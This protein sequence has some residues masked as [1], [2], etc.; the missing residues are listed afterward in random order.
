M[1]QETKRGWRWPSLT[2]Q[3]L[4]FSLIKFSRFNLNGWKLLTEN[5]YEICNVRLTGVVYL[6]SKTGGRGSN[7]ERKLTDWPLG[8]MVGNTNVCCPFNNQ[9]LSLK[10]TRRLTVC[11]CI[12]IDTSTGKYRVSYC[13]HA[14]EFYPY[15]L[16]PLVQRLL[17][18]LSASI[19]QRHRV[20]IE[21]GDLRI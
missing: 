9:Q 15:L 8:R 20:V 12:H 2:R 7:P 17:L 18:C 10:L 16:C 4:P 3:S 5:F 11:L 14:S 21:A 1:I 13:I 6:H 19:T